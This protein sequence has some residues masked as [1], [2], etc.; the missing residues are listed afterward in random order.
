ML[1]A[2]TNFED[3]PLEAL[4]LSRPSAHWLERARA[5]GLPVTRVNTARAALEDED[6]AP[7]LA[8]VP[9]SPLRAPGPF[10]ASFAP[11]PLAPAPALGA[12]TAAVLSE[13]AAEEQ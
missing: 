11:R 12:H 2:Q 3:A 10:L 5:A 13:L 6:L 7:L 4:F 1:G 9:G 8:G